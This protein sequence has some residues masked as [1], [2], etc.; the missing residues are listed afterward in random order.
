MALIV[1]LITGP[2]E[3]PVTVAEAKAHLRVDLPDDDALIEGLIIAARQWVEQYARRAL[4]TQ[5]W[6]LRADG[7]PASQFYL[8]WSPLAGVTSITGTDDDGNE[9]VVSSGNYMVDT[10]SEPGRVTLKS[11]VAW[12]GTTVRP[13]GFAVRYVAGYG[14]VGNVPRVFKQ[15]IL[16]ITGHLYEN[17][18]EVT[19]SGMT[20]ATLPMGVKALLWPYR[21]MRFD[22]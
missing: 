22:V 11:S 3:E 18:E 8:P 19:V 12:P 14:G 1:T 9:T 20:A 2:A 13:A 4:V 5:T 15:A 6:E 17:R 10:A 16:L 21:V 7:W